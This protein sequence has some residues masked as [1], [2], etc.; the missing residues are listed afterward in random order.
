[1]IAPT[2]PLTPDGV[3]VSVA[4]AA[5]APA[6]AAAAP[7]ARSAE[8]T[9]PTATT[10]TTIARRRMGRDGS[11]RTAAPKAKSQRQ[12]GSGRPGGAPRFPVVRGCEELLRRPQ[13]AAGVSLAATCAPS[14]GAGTGSAA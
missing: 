1:M 12:N 11:T 3:N 5:C 6:G 7:P 13:A 10:A 14:M 2:D 9:T 8:G 4:A